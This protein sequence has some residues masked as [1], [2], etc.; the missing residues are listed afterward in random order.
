MKQILL[1]IQFLT[2]LTVV[3]SCGQK[4]TPSKLIISTGFMTLTSYSGGLVVSAYGPNGEVQTETTLSGNIVNLNLTPG[5]WKFYVVGWNKETGGTSDELSG[6]RCGVS[7]VTISDKTTS[8]PISISPENCNHEDFKTTGNVAGTT[9]FFPLSILSCSHLYSNTSFETP[10]TSNN[11]DA[12]GFCMTGSSKDQDLVKSAK[13]YK[14]TIKGSSSEITTNCRTGV[15]SLAELPTN[16]I[17]MKVEIFESATCTGDKVSF[18]FK[19]GLGASPT[20]DDNKE[21]LGHI[22][23]SDKLNQMGAKENYLILPFNISWSG[24]SPMMGLMPSFQCSGSSCTQAPDLYADYIIPSN[25]TNIVLTRNHSPLC[26]NGGVSFEDSAFP[27]NL[28]F[29]NCQTDEDREYVSV[30]SD[31]RCSTSGCEGSFEVRPSIGTPISKT[32]QVLDVNQS[33][34]YQSLN[35]IFQAT[36][37]DYASEAFANTMWGFKD[38][39][40]EAGILGDPRSMMGTDGLFGVFGNT[41]CSNMRGEKVLSRLIDGE[42]RVFKI[43]AKD[44]NITDIPKSLCSSSTS[45]PSSCPT[46]TEKFQKVVSFR[47]LING[48]FVTKDIYHL[49]CNARIGK[50]E[51]VFNESN[52][53]DH[54]IVGWNTDQQ[55][56]TRFYHFGI[57]HLTNELKRYELKRYEST[58]V[59]RHPTNKS[60]VVSKTSFEKTTQNSLGMNAQQVERAENNVYYS[61]DG[62][63]ILSSKLAYATNAL[64]PYTGH[65]IFEQ[66]S[67]YDRYKFMTTQHALS[68]LA[69]LSFIRSYAEYNRDGNIETYLAVE[70]ES[71]KLTITSTTSTK[72]IIVKSSSSIFNPRVKVSQARGEILVAW[73]EADKA[74]SAVYDLT[75]TLKTSILNVFA[76]GYLESVQNLEINF[77]SSGYHFLWNTSSLNIKQTIVPTA[78]SSTIP[79]AL[80]VTLNTSVSI[81]GQSMSSIT[82]PS[83]PNNILV[84]YND[85]NNDDK[86]FVLDTLASYVPVQTLSGVKSYYSSLESVNGEIKLV[87]RD[88][89]DFSMTREF[90]WG[91][92]SFVNETFGSSIHLEARLKKCFK[93]STLLETTC[94]VVGR[95]KL[96]LPYEANIHFLNPQSFEQNFKSL[97]VFQNYSP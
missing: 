41:T 74:Y 71:L 83:N 43:I 55:D 92:S 72:N 88:S 75:G 93:S 39:N 1:F 61:L 17:P 12:L 10:L 11:F 81:N 14:I 56:T 84:Y 49:H 69:S 3:A 47:E 80:A 44:D 34:Y 38:G 59:Q 73:T 60:F 31:P 8:I 13:S 50:L 70:G 65:R 82:L 20:S 89:S 54:S 35:D 94:P 45:S 15:M 16:K 79:T 77:I 21:V 62:D 24:F 18:N 91:G 2:I 96:S 40:F 78:W 37:V 68:P 46:S 32:Y 22:F 4:S 51:S 9:G 27:A 90:D 33:T 66:Q 42:L 63:T 30:S 57:T 53:F 58:I 5:Q 76:V 28:F 6:S 29:G 52:E 95:A 87:S 97:N 23:A 26:S 36:G 48:S 64:E 85:P 86:Y 7:A 67:T 25:F 19:T